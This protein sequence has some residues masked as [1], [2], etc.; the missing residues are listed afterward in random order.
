MRDSSGQAKGAALRTRGLH[1]YNKI[2]SVC[3]CVGGEDHLL[4]H[5]GIDGKAYII[6]SLLLT[7]MV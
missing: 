4:F 6:S 3:V 1:F 7:Y 5:S 2:K